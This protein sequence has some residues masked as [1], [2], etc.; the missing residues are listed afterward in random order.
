MAGRGGAMSGGIAEGRRAGVVLGWE[1]LFS[2]DRGGPPRRET[3][4]T[5][6]ATMSRNAQKI[7]VP[8][9][10]PPHDG[11]AELGVLGCCLLEP[12]QCLNECEERG[13]TQAW[14][15]DL[16]FALIYA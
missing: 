3:R 6:G 10:L 11:E 1:E 8:E 12:A 9:M 15:Y 14:F 13:V 5:R 2:C 7:T 16:R 4:P